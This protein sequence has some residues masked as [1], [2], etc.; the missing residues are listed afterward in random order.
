MHSPYRLRVGRQTFNLVIGVQFSV[1]VLKEKPKT[2]KEIK[3][4]Y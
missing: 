3:H 1:G 4:G 2:I